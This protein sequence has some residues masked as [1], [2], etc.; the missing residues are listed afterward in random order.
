MSFITQYII[1]GTKGKTFGI[2]ADYPTANKEVVEA[3]SSIVGIRSVE[4]NDQ[5]FPREI[6]ICSEIP[7]AVKDIQQKA[8]SIGVHAIP[9]SYF[10]QS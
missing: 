4:L 1:P 7:I 3:L 8:K 10:Y 5:V 6:T 2:G 9:K